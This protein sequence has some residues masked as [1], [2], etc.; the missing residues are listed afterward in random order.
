MIELD[1][2][3]TQSN[4][5]QSKEQLLLLNVH[6]ALHLAKLSPFGESQGWT[7]DAVV[8]CH[9]SPHQHTQWLRLCPH[10]A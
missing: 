10:T 6:Y 1:F 5:P 3:T 4:M 2:A 7:G 8:P 9:L